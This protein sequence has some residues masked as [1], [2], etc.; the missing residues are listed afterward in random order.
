MVAIAT[1]PEFKSFNMKNQA[2][3]PCLT[4]ACVA[5]LQP[6]FALLGNVS[7]NFDHHEFL[8]A[9]DSFSHEKHAKLMHS[10]KDTIERLWIGMVTNSISHCDQALQ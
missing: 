10:M 9:G 5:S 6:V 7:L 1:L 2:T 4:H 8:K 3:C